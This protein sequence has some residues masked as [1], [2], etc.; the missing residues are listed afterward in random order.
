MIRRAR[1]RYALL[2]R[3][4]AAIIAEDRTPPAPS[5][6]ARGTV[7]GQGKTCRWCH[8]TGW[9]TLTDPILGDAYWVT[10]PADCPPAGVPS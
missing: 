4:A 8:G 9:A 6:P 1:A 2:R 10:C 3:Q 7:P 5:P